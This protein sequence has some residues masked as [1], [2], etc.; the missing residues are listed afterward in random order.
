MKP[1]PFSLVR[2]ACVCLGSL[3]LGGCA[4]TEIALEH[5]NLDVQTKMSAT[6]FLDLEKQ[7]SRTIFIDVKNTS[8]KDVNVDGLLRAKLQAKNYTI[9]ASPQDAFYILQVNID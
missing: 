4:A 3:F 9:A 2:A 7:Q 6:V 8:D 5:K 1:F